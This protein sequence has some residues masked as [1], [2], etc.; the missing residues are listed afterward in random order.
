[1]ASGSLMSEVIKANALLD[2]YGVAANIW[3][4]TSYNELYRDAIETE[5]YNRLNALDPDKQNYLQEV[6][7]NEEGLF[8]AVSDYMKAMPERIAQWLPGQLITLGTDGYGLS[9]S[10]ETLRDHF[11]VSAK[12][13]AFSALYGLYKQ[14]LLPELVLIKAKVDLNIDGDKRSPLVS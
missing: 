4:V 10:R 6:M 5:R 14:K 11:E 3:S 13:I 12:H 7:V 9:E 2:D 1:M 8:I